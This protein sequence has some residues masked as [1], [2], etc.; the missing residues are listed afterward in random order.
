MHVSFL[1][2]FKVVQV[3]LQVQLAS[4]DTY[5]QVALGKRFPPWSA[6]KEEATR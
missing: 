5:S 6:E 3:Q 1:S 4:W 2:C